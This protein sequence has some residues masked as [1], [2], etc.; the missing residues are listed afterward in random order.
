MRKLEAGQFWGFYDYNRAWYSAGVIKRERMTDEVMFGIYCDGG[1]TLGET[2][3]RW[4]ELG[5]EPPSARLEAF[6]E[7]WR[8]YG[9]LPELLQWMITRDHKMPLSCGEF[10]AKLRSLG[11]RDITE[12]VPK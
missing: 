11:F 10:C 1:G 4:Y 7:D 2:A 5:K 9:D 12:T 3:M 6:D 8:L